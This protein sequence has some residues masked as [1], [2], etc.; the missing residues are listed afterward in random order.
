MAT[1]PIAATSNTAETTA[2]GTQVV[3]DGNPGAALDRDAF[4]K[5][6]VAQLKY[7]DPTNPADTS[8]IMT[9]SA[10]LTMVDRLNEM[11]TAFETSNAMSRMSL[12]SSMVGK[13]VSFL[14]SDGWPVWARVDGVSIDGD[15]VT[16]AAGGYSVPLE[17]IGAV[18]APEAAA[19]S[20]TV[21]S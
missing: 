6:L 15:V 14:G 12:A 17:A 4:L 3:T 18:L 1:T 21:T 19:P 11:A 16:I 2:G 7:Q 20:S 8:Q 10:Q 13:D 5:L 9:Q